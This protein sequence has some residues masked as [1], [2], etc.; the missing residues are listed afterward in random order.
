MQI[1]PLIISIPFTIF[2]A[3]YSKNY[4]YEKAYCY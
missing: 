1:F 2:V 4:P 3:C